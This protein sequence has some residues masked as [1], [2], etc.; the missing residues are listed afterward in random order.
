[1][2]LIHTVAATAANPLEGSQV[3]IIA[4]RTAQQH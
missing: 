3:L 1:M 2:L 4:L